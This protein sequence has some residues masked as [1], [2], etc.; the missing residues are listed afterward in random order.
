MIIFLLQLNCDS[1]INLLT[2][3]TYEERQNLYRSINFDKSLCESLFFR[4]KNSALIGKIYR[5]YKIAS[6]L[7]EISDFLND[8]LCKAKVYWL[9]GFLNYCEGHY[10]DAV[11]YFEK[12]LDIFGQYHDTL[13]KG[14][15]L[16]ALAVT[17]YYQGRFKEAMKNYKRALGIFKKY[18]VND[19]IECLN[20]IGL[21]YYQEQKFDSALFYYHKACS[22]LPCC[23]KEKKKRILPLLYNN[24]G[25]LYD[26]IYLKKLAKKY[27]LKIIKESNFKW[28]L[29]CAYANIGRL[30]QERSEEDSAILFLL[31]S[32]EY[33]KKIRNRRGEA[34]VYNNLSQCYINSD[35][36]KA[37]FYARRA[38]KLNSET[39]D[40]DN[41][42]YCL[43][44]ISKIFLS[45]NYRDS[46]LFYINKMLNM[47]RFPVK[48][49]W[50][51]FLLKG[52][53][54]FDSSLFYYKKALETLEAS[55]KHARKIEVKAGLYENLS[56]PY[57]KIAEFFAKRGKKDSVLK[58][59]ELSSQNVLKEVTGYKMGV[60]IRRLREKLRTLQI[61]FIANY[62]NEFLILFMRNDSI[63]V[64]LKDIPVESLRSVKGRI[65]ESLINAVNMKKI[66]I[67][68]RELKW[69]YDKIFSCIDSFIDTSSVLFIVPHFELL[70]IP[71]ECLWDGDR[72]L[73][74]RYKIVYL[75]SLSLL[76]KS[77]KRFGNL[78]LYAYGKELR[79]TIAEVNAIKSIWGTAVVDTSGKFLKAVSEYDILHLAT[80]GLFNED[81]IMNSGVLLSDDT[82]CLNEVLKMNLN[83]SLCVL[84]ACETSFLVRY[85]SS[86]FFGLV[87]AFI[88]RG[89]DF[90]VSSNW[91]VRDVIAY[92]FM[93]AFYKKLRE[94]GD[95][96]DAM[97]YARVSLLNKYKHPAF[98]STFI[99]VGCVR[100]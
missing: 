29:A 97:K 40:Y 84:S 9:Y 98:W 2:K 68:Y 23:E 4:A 100:K 34:Q 47:E 31:K 33:Y 36:H 69:L 91:P 59:L 79:Y 28:A 64:F 87:F 20:N 13:N 56:K 54:V 86:P 55:I 77:K 48:L 15:A 35:W 72:F 65:F 44:F 25:V 62:E 92:N 6:Y 74:E 49:K 11:P 37:L 94:T 51:V 80:H 93:V 90:V 22:L 21:C 88:A 71:V 30:Y 67:P 82:L 75:P 83:L 39:G 38:L 10:A 57:F 26:K 1:L 85:P 95:V 66:E 7:D 32:L 89:T 27:W 99:L 5:G 8:S 78:L 70:E 12:S 52:D 96:V 14:R 58:Y 81:D 61:A 24:I 53:I 60:N 42:C 73:G 45:A 76:R 43:F 46:A 19:E 41:Y 17:L 50:R 63:H 18:S 16:H 3:L